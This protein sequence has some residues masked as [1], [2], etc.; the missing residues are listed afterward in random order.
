M[1][2]V[3]TV[4]GPQRKNWQSWNPFV[5]VRHGIMSSREPFQGLSQFIVS[6][7][8]RAVVKNDTYAWRD[9]VVLNGARLAR[10]IFAEPEAEGRPIVL[11]GHSMGGLVCRVANLLLT[12]PNLIPQNRPIFRIYCGGDDGDFN[13]LLGLGLSRYEQREVNLVVTLGTPNSGAMLKAQL[14]ALGDLAAEIIPSKFKSLE[15]LSN[16]RLFRLFQ[17]FSVSTPMLSISGS[18]WNRLGK[19]H[20]PFRLWAAHLGARLHLPNDMI[21]EDRS[22]DLEQSIFPNEILSAPHAKYLHVRL[23]LD[24]TEV[25]HTTMY[26]HGKLRDVLIDCMDRCSR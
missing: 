2:S 25:I 15:D 24:C 16:A 11:I 5:V 26:D 3:E 17:Y 19:A 18:G 7:F 13:T 6:K 22:V 8:P 21:V 23:Y 20:A 12:Q 10:D 9:S 14:N 1:D 4:F